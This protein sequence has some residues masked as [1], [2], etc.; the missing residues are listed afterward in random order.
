M[1]TRKS[2]AGR[3]AR[4][5]RRMIE[6]GG[7]CLTLLLPPETVAAL[8]ALLRAGYAPNRRQAILRALDEASARAA[9]TAKAAKGGDRT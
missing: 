2:S 7:C 1:S 8:R 5:R 4:H 6:R 9:A 3:V